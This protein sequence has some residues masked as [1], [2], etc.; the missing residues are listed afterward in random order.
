MSVRVKICG[1]TRLEDAREAARAGASAIGMIL[2]PESPRC[3]SI[4]RAAV[5]VAAT[6]RDDITRVGVFVNQPPEFVGEAIRHA[7]L[8]AIQLHGQEPIDAYQFGVPVIKAFGVGHAWHVGLLD[9][10]PEP[11]LALLDA[12]DGRRSGGMGIAIDW[13]M[14]ATAASLRPIVL[15]GGLGPDNVARAISVA[16]PYAVDVSSGVEVS[17]GV[18]DARRVRA[19]IEAVEAVSGPVPRRLFK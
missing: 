12:T 6:D 11:V 2:W 10:L 9:N 8:D 16:G 4:D 17:P 19:F 14:A 13:A 5:I 15:A 1:I 3:V 7:R 18:K